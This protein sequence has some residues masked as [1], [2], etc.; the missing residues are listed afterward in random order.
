MN[1]DHHG[2]WAIGDLLAAADDVLN[3]LGPGMLFGEGVLL[4]GEPRNATVRAVEP[5]EM[6]VL[7]RAGL[8]EEIF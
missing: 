2:A 7:N 6:L 8:P 3:T 5:C 1:A 4:T